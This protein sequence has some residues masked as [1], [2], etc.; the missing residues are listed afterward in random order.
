MDEVNE[1]IN[2]NKSL[3]EFLQH[4]LDKNYNCPVYIKYQQN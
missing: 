1:Q 4:E 3:I 2:L